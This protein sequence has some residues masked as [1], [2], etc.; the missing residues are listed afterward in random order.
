M[1][2]GIGGIALMMLGAW[3]ASQITPVL[4]HE[5]AS[6]PAQASESGVASTPTPA[7]IR[8][9]LRASPAQAV[10][11]LDGVRLES[12][13]YASSVPG[14]PGEHELRV[15][16]DGFTPVVRSLRFD[17]DI[18]LRLSLEPSAVASASSKNTPRASR[19]ANGR[20][21]RRALSRSKTLPR[22]AAS[23]IHRTPSVQAA[24]S[25]NES[26]ATDPCNPPYVVNELGIKRYKREC[27]K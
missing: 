6:V 10:L 12:T 2:F 19:T 4:Q 3:I 17:A 24:A 8:L 20:A 25:S 14:D 18:E 23:S 5:I 27:L 13:P 15:V 1:L 9:A 21:G 26:A 22:A 11:F 16:A 7:T